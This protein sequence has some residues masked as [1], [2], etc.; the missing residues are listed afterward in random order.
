MRD[1][2]RIPGILHDVQRVWEV[3]PDM[4]L[5]QLL[6]NVAADPTLYY[7][8]DDELVHRLLEFSYRF[9]KDSVNGKE[10]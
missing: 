3:F 6:L 7:L 10:S 4:R 5:G 2:K 1:P 9:A 8:E